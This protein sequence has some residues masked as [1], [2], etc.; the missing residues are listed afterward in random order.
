MVNH[1]FSVICVHNACGTLIS[2]MEKDGYVLSEDEVRLVGTLCESS[3]GD[4]E[5]N[6][7]LNKLL[8]Q[9]KGNETKD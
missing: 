4:F 8:E 3:A 9:T 2:I 5:S 7:I 1:P 6:Q